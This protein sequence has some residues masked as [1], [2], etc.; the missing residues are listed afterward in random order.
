MCEPGSLVM[1]RI[2]QPDKRFV[3]TQYDRVY[4][5]LDGVGCSEGSSPLVGVNPEVVADAGVLVVSTSSA[6]VVRRGAVQ[7]QV[8]QVMPLLQTGG[9]FWGSQRTVLLLSFSFSQQSASSH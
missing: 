3:Q 1:G 5:L 6:G 4:S 8:P 7:S 2:L 9:K